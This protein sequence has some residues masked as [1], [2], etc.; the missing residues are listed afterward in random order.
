MKKNLL[1]K[2]TAIASGSVLSLTSVSAFAE[3]QDVIVIIFT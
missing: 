1:N 3:V 2:L